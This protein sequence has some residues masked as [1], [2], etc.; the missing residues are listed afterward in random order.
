MNNHAGPADGLQD[1]AG[2]GRRL[3]KARR[4]AGLSQTEVGLRL[5]VPQSRVAKL[6]T[7]DRRLQYLEAFAYAALYEVEPGFFQPD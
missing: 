7:G 3:A 5:A 1:H 4:A 2:V 6:E